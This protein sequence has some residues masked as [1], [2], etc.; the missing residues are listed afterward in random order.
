MKIKHYLLLAFATLLFF[1]TISAQVE[2]DTIFIATWNMENLFDAIDDVDKRDEDFLPDGKKNWTQEVIDTKIENQAKVIKW[3]NNG[4]GPDLMG[5]QEVEHKHLIDTL[6]NR[7]FKDKN[8]KVAYEE[9]PDKRGIDNGLIYDADKFEVLNIKP[10]EVELPSKYP[11]RYI[12]EILIKIKNGE[13]I[14]LFVNHWPSRGGGEVRS[15]PNRIK[16]A[17]VLR[18]EIDSLYSRNEK[19]NIVILGDFNDM[20]NNKSI[21]R[22]LWTHEYGCS[23]RVE[24]KRLFNLA[25]KEFLAGKGTYLYRGNWNMLDQIIVSSKMVDDGKVKYVPDSFQLIKPD[26]MITQSGKYKGAATP[27][28]GG[29]K[30]IGGYSDHIPVAAKFTVS[31]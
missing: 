14:Y 4:N 17:S 10:I 2:K 30:Y 12:L 25:Y 26:F 1:N 6:L 3:M 27:T 29:R 9:S 24:P 18:E 19:L 11:T 15:R 20:P 28:F 16:A 31:N 8:Y 21:A 23:E 13:E 5:F 22:Y 7:N